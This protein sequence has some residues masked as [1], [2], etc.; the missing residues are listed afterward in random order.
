MKPQ[1]IALLTGLA[2]S[3]CGPIVQI[4]GNAKPPASLLTLHATATPRPYA[5]PSNRAET[6]GVELPGTPATLQTLRLPVNTTASEVAYLAGATWSEQP[7]R[8]FQRLLAD[9]LAAAGLAVIDVRQS[10]VAPARTLTGVL[11]DFGLDVADPANPVVRV[12]FDA[13]IA[14]AQIANAQIA[15]ARSPQPILLLRRFEAVEPA[16]DQRPAAVAAALNRAANRMAGEISEWAA[17]R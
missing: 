9:T 6:I 3:A 10:H 5:G 7:N 17:G 11:R 12:R 15:N 4:G 14:S 13:Q 1:F 16:I 2:L 8:Q